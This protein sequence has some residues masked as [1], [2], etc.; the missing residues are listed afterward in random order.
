MKKSGVVRK[1]RKL[2]DQQLPPGIEHELIYRLGCLLAY[3]EELV[4]ILEI[5]N[6]DK[7]DVLNGRKSVINKDDRKY[8]RK[9]WLEDHEAKGKKFDNLI[10]PES[11]RR[12]RRVTDRK[13]VIQNRQ[14]DRIVTKG[15]NRAIFEE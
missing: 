12:C 8:D 4:I 3:S 2:L 6:L 10:L 14:E 5:D 7:E 1:F 11:W 9:G 15:L 13:E